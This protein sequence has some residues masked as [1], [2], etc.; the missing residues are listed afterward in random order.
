MV[1]CDVTMDGSLI[2]H[3]GGQTQYRFT[4]EYGTNFKWYYTKNLIKNLNNMKQCNI[5][6]LGLNIF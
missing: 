5:W 1:F 2:S 3:F 6:T 4:N